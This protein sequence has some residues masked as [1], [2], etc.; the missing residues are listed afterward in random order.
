[1]LV[2]VVYFG[3][4]RLSNAEA[5]PLLRW[6]TVFRKKKKVLSTLVY[7]DSNEISIVLRNHLKFFMLCLLRLDDYII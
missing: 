4:A 7:F 6:V 1:M 5:G 3:S 2:A